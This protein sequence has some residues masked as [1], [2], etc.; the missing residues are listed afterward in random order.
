MKKNI[1]LLMFIQLFI[2]LGFGMIIPIM[3]EIINQLNVN[4][5]HLGSLLAVHSLISFVTAPMWG[6]MSDQYGRKRLIVIGLLG[7][8]FSFTLFGLTITNL[9]G[10][11]AARI[12]SGFFSSALYTATIS[13]VADHTTYEN[14][15]KYMG[16][17][18]ISIGL[19]FILGPSI[20]GLLSVFGLAVP[21]FSSAIILVCLTLLT[22]VRLSE[23]HEC[24]Q[25][26]M[27]ERFSIRKQWIWIRHVKIIPLLLFTFIATLLMAGLESIFQLYEIDKVGISPFQMGLLFMFSGVIDALVQGMIVPSIKPGDESRWVIIGQLASGLA[28][29]LIPFASSLWTVGIC[30]ALFTGGNALVRTCVISLITLHAGKRQGI[31][32]G[33]SYS[34]DSIGRIIGPL[35]FTWTLTIH[36][37]ATFVIL[38]FISFISIY[39]IIYYKKTNTQF[40]TTT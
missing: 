13:Y 2:Y 28:L 4:I 11:Y 29:L 38:S 3:P 23:S 26:S 21:F 32:S 40:I 36:A 31:A 24:V 17:L 1:L 18:G 20:G 19:G 12:M 14:R 39:L 33:I 30:L 7:Y 25:D 15:T 27:K 10:L 5:I 34:L 8:A 16:F 9:T 35:L 22:W 37:I 6:V